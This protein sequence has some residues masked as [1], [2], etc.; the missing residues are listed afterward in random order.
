METRNGTEVDNTVNLLATLNVL[1]NHSPPQA[2]N[3]I[4]IRYH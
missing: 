2:H 3:R 1:L 4:E